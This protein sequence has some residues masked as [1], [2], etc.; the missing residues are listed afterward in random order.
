MLIKRINISCHEIITGCTEFRYPGSI[1]T[2]DGTDTK[3]IRHRV[4]QARKIIGALNGVWWLKDITKNRKKVIYSSMVKSVLIYGAET[5]SLCE[6]DRRRINA[7][8]M[9]AFRRSAGISKLGR[10][11]NE[12]IREKI[13]AQG[14]ILDEITRKQLILYGHVERTD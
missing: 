6:D 9:D 2:K 5:W 4:T 7:T 3:S 8:E 13:N 1:F 11:M 14:T 12:Y 10:K